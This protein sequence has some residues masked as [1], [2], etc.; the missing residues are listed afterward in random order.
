MS[1]R[2][3]A[4]RASG[5]PVVFLLSLP[6]SGSTLLQ[7]LLAAHPQI[8]ACGEPWLAL[9]ALYSLRE[10]GVDSEY[11]HRTAARGIR[12]FCSHCLPGGEREYREA[13]RDH[14]NRLYTS[15][16]HGHRYF[17]DKTPRYHL[18]ADELLDLFPNAH[19]LFLW[20][21]PLAIAASLLES[22][23]Q[24]R[25]NLD[26]HAIDLYAGTTRLIGASMR[27]ELNATAI[28]YE[29][30]VTSPELEL[31][32]LLIWLGLDLPTSIVDRYA[33]APLAGVVGDTRG[34]RR[35][36]TISTEP[37]DKWKNTLT[38]P[39]RKA[40]ANRYLDWLG[41]ERLAH[42]GYDLHELKAELAT[43]PTSPDHL[44]GDL[45]RNLYAAFCRTLAAAATSR[46]RLPWP[47]DESGWR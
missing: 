33:S 22:W 23:N 25:W 20:R 38:N 5:P 31:R 21:N 39:L 4:E 27:T 46:R 45:A 44:A 1:A 10:S 9:P 28:R 16:A 32:R 6:R 29:D 36:R 2:Q 43:V 3:V 30:L 42:Q 17:L 19:F 35:Y 26:V 34:T 15:A 24:G 8:A 40:W 47:R 13:L 11:D 12:S 14:L 37:L 41:E 18:I 7:R